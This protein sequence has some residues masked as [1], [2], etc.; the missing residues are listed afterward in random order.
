MDGE[1]AGHAHYQIRALGNSVVHMETD[2]VMM[3]DGHVTKMPREKFLKFADELENDYWH[4]T[5]NGYPF[6][7]RDV[8]SPGHPGLP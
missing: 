2:N 7:P 3:F 8:R 6:Y 1:F 4:R 5:N